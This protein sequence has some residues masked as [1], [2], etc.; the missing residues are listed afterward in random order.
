MVERQGTERLTDLG[1]AGD[2]GHFI[3]GVHRRENP[4]DQRAGAGVEFRQLDHDP[5]TCRQGTR[6]AI[7][8]HVPREVPGREDAHHPQRLVAHPG[9]ASVSLARLVAHPLGDLALGV[10]HRRQRAEYIEQTREVI[11]A[12][13][14]VGRQGGDDIVLIINQ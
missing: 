6:Q 3:L 4:R 14:E 1:T 11:T 2:D 5:V 12:M 7:E 10:L 9:L 8:D 13:T